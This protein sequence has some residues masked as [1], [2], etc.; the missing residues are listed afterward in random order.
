M[1]YRGEGMAIANESG[2]PVPATMTGQFAQSDAF[3]SWGENKQR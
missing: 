2:L 1:R 3:E